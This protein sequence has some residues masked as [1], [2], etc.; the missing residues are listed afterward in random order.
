MVFFPFQGVIGRTISRIKL[1]TMKA[2]DHR[3]RLM[4]EILTAVKLVKLYAWESCEFEARQLFG[5]TS[6]GIELSHIFFLWLSSISFLG[7][8]GCS[9]GEGTRLSAKD[10]Q[11][12]GD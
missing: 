8:C 4:S 7:V 5:V 1:E 2:V 11:L 10:R 12:E 9:K 6:A 3:V